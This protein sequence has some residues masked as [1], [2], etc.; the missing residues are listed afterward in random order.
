MLARMNGSCMIQI[1]RQT[2]VKDFIHYG[3][4]ARTGYTCHTGHHSQWNIYINMLQI[5]LCCTDNMQKSC[6]LPS[7]FWY[8]N[9]DPAAQVST[10][11]GLLT[12]H[13]ILCGSFCNKISAMLTGSR[14]DI[15]NPV[16]FQHGILIMLHHNQRITE[17][18]QI[19][20]GLQQLVIVSLMQ[21]D[22][23]FIQ[24]I[25]HTNKA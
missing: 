8:R 11:Y 3:T 15:H 10:C 25:S 6:R 4:L 13:D 19:L 20:Q 12:L 5:I 23:R 21:T 17:I 24:N 18:S 16:R 7:L 22:T 2:L 14:T 1:S 9:F